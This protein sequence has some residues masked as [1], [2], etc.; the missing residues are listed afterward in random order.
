MDEESVMDSVMDNSTESPPFEFSDYTQRVIVATMFLIAFVVGTIGNSL[1]ILAVLLS[2]K[3]RTTTNAFVVSLS[4][5]DLLTCLVIPWNAVALLGKDGLPVGEWICSIV[6]IAQATT[7]GCSLYMLASI[8]LNRLLLITRASTTYRVIFTPRKIAV[9]LLLIWLIPLL[10]VLLPPVLNVG[11][12]GFNPKYHTCGSISSHPKSNYYDLII[13]GTLYPIPLLTLLVCYILIWRHLYLHAKRMVSSPE[14]S[15]D[16]TDNRLSVVSKSV[17]TINSNHSHQSRHSHHHLPTSPSR[18]GTVSRSRMSRR[19]TEITKNMFYI[20]C[21]FMLCL[22]PYA[23]C[24]FFDDSDPVLPY[25]AA[26]LF[27]N[28]CINPFIYATKHPH[29]KTVFGCIFRRQW[30]HIPDPSDSL[31]ALRSRCSCGRSSVYA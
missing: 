27:I 9:W 14:A 19:Q 10:I 25:A 28:S 3:L 16:S 2:K 17:V 26:I 24:L 8:G 7:V 18:S 21:G 29:F 23:I 1:V 11:A 4:I 6:A 15:F 5:A 12:V 30:D 20:V 22:T 13:V 31:K